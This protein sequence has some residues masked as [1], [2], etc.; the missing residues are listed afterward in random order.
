L[1]LIDAAIAYAAAG[2]LIERRLD[3][4]TE[5]PKRNNE[6]TYTTCRCWTRSSPP[7]EW[8]EYRIG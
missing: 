6:D 8:P 5:T 2:P 3:C 7:N 4:H 1:K